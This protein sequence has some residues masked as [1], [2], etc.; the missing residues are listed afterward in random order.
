MKKTYVVFCEEY[1]FSMNSLSTVLK[2]KIY[3]VSYSFKTAEEIR[4][5]MKKTLD[6]FIDDGELNVKNE[7][8][9]AYNIR[10]ICL[11]DKYSFDEAEKIV[12]N[13]DY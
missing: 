2:K 13:G 12:L 9:S 8:L 11:D 1:Y 5:T 4:K 3:N 10:T 7:I 6:S